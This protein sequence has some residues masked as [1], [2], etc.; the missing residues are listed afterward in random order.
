MVVAGATT[1]AISFA[2]APASKA[3]LS[4]SPLV[5]RSVLLCSAA[6]FVVFSGSR[7]FGGQAG[8]ADDDSYTIR[9]IVVNSA[10]HAAVPRA[11]VFTSDNR[12]AMLTDDEGHFEFKVPRPKDDQNSGS[13]NVA[14]GQFGS[15]NLV[16][17]RI[18]TAETFLARKP[19]YF[20]SQGQTWMV[21][22]PQSPSELRIELVPEALIVGRV[23]LP[24]Q[25]GTERIQVQVYR[26]QVQDGQVQWVPAGG[27]TTRANGDF[28]V[29]KLQQGDYKLFTSELLER[30]PLTFNPRGPA[31]G[32]PPIYYPAAGDF[33]S[34]AV[35]HLKVGET[36]QAAL[37]PAKREYYP[38]K[39]GVLNA[40]S[41]AGLQL[42]VEPQGRRGP[43]FSLSYN[44]N[45]SSIEGLLPNGTYRVEVTQ[46]GESGAAGT[47][48]FSVNGARVEGPTVMLASNPPIEVRVRD[49]RTKSTNTLAPGMRNLVNSMNVRLV[50]TDEFGPTN[51]LRLQ[52]PQNPDDETLW[53][54]GTLPGS[55][56]VRV[57]NSPVGYVAALTSGGTDLLRQPLVV[58]IGAAVP[59]LEITIRDDGARVDGNIENWP[60]GGRNGQGLGF[61][62][63][64]PTVVLLP[65]P[66]STGQFCQAWVMPDGQFNFAQVAPGDY[67]AIAFDHSPQGLEYGNAEAM[68]K[69]ESKGQVLRLEAEQAEHLRLS[70][71]GGS[72]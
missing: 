68:K 47:L 63:N 59:P 23:N 20:Q 54:A 1:T 43:G 37:T 65:L 31:H 52:P 25:D 4:S 8:Q 7:A 6:L 66:D 55:Y 12:F 58:G 9:G 49:E 39:L 36:F 72:D 69:Y 40:P 29:A 28:R 56:R 26:K 13:G 57:G 38:V 35:I 11:L 34:A 18:V 42:Q 44:M 46:Y 21:G 53:F 32:Y 41:G 45:D 3:S 22:G 19:G 71:D 17:G 5:L 2:R 15:A 30:D 62:R 14:G 61:S 27:V 10:T 33:E 51:Y 67:R 48:N 70:L 24:V 64:A 50:S 16:R 60:Q